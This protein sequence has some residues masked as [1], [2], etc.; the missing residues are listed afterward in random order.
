MK[1]FFTSAVVVLL[2]AFSANA[3]TVNVHRTDHGP[4]DS[5]QPLC[6]P[7]YKL[8]IRKHTV[9][10]WDFIITANSSVDDI[11]IM[12]RP[13]D[14]T[15]GVYLYGNSKQ[16]RKGDGDSLIV[17]TRALS[18]PIKFSVYTHNYDIDKFFTFQNHQYGDYGSY[19]NYGNGGGHSWAH[20]YFT[21]EE[22]ESNYVEV[23]FFA[24]VP[25]PM[26]AALLPFGLGALG[27]LKRR[28][29]KQTA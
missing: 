24:P 26:T 13:F 28:R 3:A 6:T 27:L 8:Q 18:G 10:F 11:F 7:A 22:S 20:A 2:F 16:V 5:C 21:K 19:L 15:D 9:G 29:N 4:N 12:T 14:V 1:T 25:L 23:E 17:D